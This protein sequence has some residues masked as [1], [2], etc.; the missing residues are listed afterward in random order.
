[1]KRLARV[2]LPL[3]LLA[4]ITALTIGATCNIP[5]FATPQICFLLGGS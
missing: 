1:M 5:A 4:A 3:V 2:S